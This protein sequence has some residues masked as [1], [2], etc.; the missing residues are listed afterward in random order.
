MATIPF[1]R[2]LHNSFGFFIM[3]FPFDGRARDV[4]ETNH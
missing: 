2:Q 3:V 4:A 1:Q